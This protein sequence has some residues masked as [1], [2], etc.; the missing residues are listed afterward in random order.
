MIARALT[1]AHVAVD[2][3]CGELLGQRPAH[4]QVIE[5]HPRVAAPRVAQ[6]VPKRIHRLVRMERVDRVGPALGYQAG[7]RGARRGLDE[8][9]VLPRAQ[10][11]DVRIGWDHVV[12]A[13]E[14]HGDLA[15]AVVNSARVGNEAFE[16]C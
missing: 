15:L 4:E 2:V 1:A 12:V 10:R 3:R 14:E 13:D 11:V 16:P 8:R 7:V 9:V 5:P 6:V